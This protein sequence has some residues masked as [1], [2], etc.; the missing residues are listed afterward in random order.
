[1]HAGAAGLSSDLR[2]DIY[3]MMHPW[4]QFLADKT[5]RIV[6]GETPHPLDDPR[7]WIQV[8]E[9][10]EADL[11]QRIAAERAKPRPS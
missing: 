10:D 3:L 9:D 4:D 2:P 8:L 5:G 11:R 1:L 7:A 6:S